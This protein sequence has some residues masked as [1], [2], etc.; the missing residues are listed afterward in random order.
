M[1]T[2]MLIPYSGEDMLRLFDGKVVGEGGGEH[3]V[4]TAVV[5]NP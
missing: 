3:T 1:I 2:N 4:H 5:W